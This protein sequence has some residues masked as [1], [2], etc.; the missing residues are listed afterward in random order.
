MKKI[1]ITSWLIGGLLILAPLFMMSCKK[2][3]EEERESKT[4]AKQTN[5]R[6]IP[7]DAL[8]VIEIDLKGFATKSKVAQLKEDIKNLVTSV[9]EEEL[10]SQ[11]AFFDNPLNL[12]IDFLKPMYAFVPKFDPSKESS[13]SIFFALE[14][15][16]QSKLID[17]LQSNTELTTKEIDDI[18]WVYF[19]NT[20]V[21]AMTGNTLLISGTNDRIANYKKILQQNNNFFATDAG[22]FMAQHSG[23]ITCMVNL[24]SL[25]EVV[26]KELEEELDELN[27]IPEVKKIL[28]SLSNTQIVA[29]INF[30]PGK[31]SLNLF[32]KGLNTQIID[33]VCNTIQPRDLEQLPNNLLAALALGVDGKEIWNIYQD[34]I[35][36]NFSHNEREEIYQYKDLCNSIN[37]TILA[38]A[39]LTE[40]SQNAEPEML[41]VV[42]TSKSKVENTFG[43]LLD[44]L[45][46][47]FYIGG[48]N[49]HFTIS[50]LSNYQYGKVSEPFKNAAN[51]ASCYA[52]AYINLKPIIDVTL[53]EQANK[54]T[55]AE[56][57]CFAEIQSLFGLMDYI[58]LKVKRNEI[59]L[60]LNLTDSSENSLYLILNRFMNCVKVFMEDENAGEEAIDQLVNAARGAINAMDDYSGSNS[61]SQDD[62]YYDY[63]DDYSYDDYSYDDY[64]DDDYGYDYCY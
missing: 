25:P 53:N 37:G 57:K 15:K 51:A 6:I 33:R 31:V 49:S 58:D 32:T 39:G 24:K 35:A 41:V 59:S 40:L 43:E 12:G 60:A 10:T 23:D 54:L 63:L 45:P 13:P 1:N 30:E 17:Y 20:V 44:E 28:S 26:Y 61:D 22:K 18:F 34:I 5:L 16:D 46:N 9:G 8:V 29:N 64:S 62:Y 7:S 56:K 55:Y 48:D 52:Y 19:D 2:S 14:I 27:E 3:K 38:S 42:P 50:N 36:P 21:A 4:V 11:M 47:N